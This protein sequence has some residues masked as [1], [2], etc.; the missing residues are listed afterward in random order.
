MRVCQKVQKIIKFNFV[1]TQ[2]TNDINQLYTYPPPPP[3]KSIF[4]SSSSLYKTNQKSHHSTIHINI[5]YMFYPNHHMDSSSDSADRLWRRLCF[6]WCLRLPPKVTGSYTFSR[7]ASAGLTTHSEG[8][9]LYLIW[10]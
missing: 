3:S 5:I 7:L 1:I 6:P 9:I 2:M 4:F 10:S 8:G